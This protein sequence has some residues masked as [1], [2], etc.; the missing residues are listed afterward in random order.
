MTKCRIAPKKW[1]KHSVRK[2]L[3]PVPK[4]VFDVLRIL[5]KGVQKIEQ[6]VLNDQFG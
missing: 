6:V 4:T 2:E 3:I 1:G 5:K